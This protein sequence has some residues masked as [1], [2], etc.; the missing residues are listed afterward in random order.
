MRVFEVF[1][2]LETVYCFDIGSKHGSRGAAH[3]AKS[4]R[5]SVKLL[6]K[7]LIMATN[8]VYCFDIGSDTEVSQEGLS[9][10]C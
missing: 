2:R 8:T 10:P 7:Y 6:L 4:L 3:V 1:F 5:W 9:L